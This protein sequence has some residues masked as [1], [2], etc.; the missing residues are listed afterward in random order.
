MTALSTIAS[1]AR[2]LAQERIVDALLRALALR[3]P[4]LL[5]AVRNILLDTELTHSGKPPKGE[6]VHEWIRKR[7]DFAAE[8]ATTHGS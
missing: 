1:D 5:E 7:L 4:D 2:F 6:T 3:E 8:F